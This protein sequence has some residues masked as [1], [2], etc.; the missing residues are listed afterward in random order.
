MTTSPSHLDIHDHIEQLVEHHTHREPYS[1]RNGQ[2]LAIF[3]HLT[4]V[5]PLID[6]LDEANATT[7]GD[8]SGGAGYSSRPAASIE[9][10]D[11][12]MFIDDEA[13]RWVRRLGE[14]DP[15]D[16]KACI[17]RVHALHASQ[18]AATKAD[19][20]RAVKRWW[21][22]ARITSGWDSPAWRPDNTCPVCEVRRSLRIKLADQMAHCVECRSLWLPEE[23]GLLA[24]WIRLENA[25]DEETTE[26]E[27]S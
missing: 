23:I 15:S 4:M 14:D 25:E 12:L 8:V 13:A 3:T 6:Q 18:D 17:R 5:P 2:Q 24:D 19:I 27:A 11:T 20:E 21:S 1:Y 7:K 10:I 22:Q 16:T 9:S 26:E